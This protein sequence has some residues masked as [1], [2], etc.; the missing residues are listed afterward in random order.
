MKKKIRSE[1]KLIVFVHQNMHCLYSST[2]FSSEN[3]YKQY[4]FLY[5]NI[6]PIIIKLFVWNNYNIDRSYWRIPMQYQNEKTWC[7]Y[8]H[9]LNTF[10]NKDSQNCPWCKNGKNGNKFAI[11]FALDLDLKHCNTEG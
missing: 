6:L 4:V 8:L 11:L 10:E 1:E 7:T 2:Y 9:V 5:N 3:N